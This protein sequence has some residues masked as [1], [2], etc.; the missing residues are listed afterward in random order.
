MSEFRDAKGLR[1]V[2]DSVLRNDSMLGLAEIQPD[3]RF[4]VRVPENITDG[5]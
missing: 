1:Y 4:A 5:G 3:A 2:A